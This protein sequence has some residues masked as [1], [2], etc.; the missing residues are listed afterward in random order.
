MPLS[1]E[2]AEKIRQAQAKADRRRTSDAQV[3]IL[4]RLMKSLVKD[5]EEGTAEVVEKA[6]RQ[7]VV[8]NANNRQNSS[9]KP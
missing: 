6:A 1:P 4:F 9:E 8:D 2:D 5:G 7:I 3:P